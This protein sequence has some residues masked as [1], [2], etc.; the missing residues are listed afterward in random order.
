VYKELLWLVNCL[1]LHVVPDIN[2][3]PNMLW[4]IVMLQKGTVCNT[5]YALFYSVFNNYVEDVIFPFLFPGHTQRCCNCILAKGLHT[6]CVTPMW[7]RTAWKSCGLILRM[8][9]EKF[10]KMCRTWTVPCQPIRSVRHLWCN[11][12]LNGAR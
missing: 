10:C 4:R 6:L 1:L 8:C 2:F 7:W 9:N 11:C 3:P 5:F 12:C